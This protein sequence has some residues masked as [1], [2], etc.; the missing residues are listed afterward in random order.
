VLTDIRKQLAGE[1]AA[2]IADL[3]SAGTLVTAPGGHGT[4]YGLSIPTLCSLEQAQA[5]VDARIAEGSEYIKSIYDN[6]KALGLSFPTLN[7]DTLKAVIAAAHA[8]KKL[9]VVHIGW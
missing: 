1:K 9:A 2:D 5:F 4:E 8:R 6:G 3:R 7:L